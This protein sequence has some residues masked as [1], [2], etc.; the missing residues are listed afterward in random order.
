MKRNIVGASIRPL[1]H[2]CLQMMCGL[3]DADYWAV[4][5]EPQEEDSDSN[6]VVAVSALNRL[7]CGLGGKTVFPQ[8]LALSARDVTIRRSLCLTRSWTAS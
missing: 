6:A 8:I 1:V 3:E 7:A 2:V 4:S 5:D